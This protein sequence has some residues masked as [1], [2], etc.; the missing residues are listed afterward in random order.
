MNKEDLNLEVGTLRKAKQ[1]LQLQLVD[2]DNKISALH[3]KYVEEYPHSIKVGSKVRIK[4][5][6]KD[7][8]GA[9]N[10]E[11][12]I[13]F[14]G[15]NKYSKDYDYWYSRIYPDVN[16]VAKLLKVKKNGTPSERC[17]RLTGNI[18]EIEILEQ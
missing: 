1:E 5:S 12:I 13:A 2:I 16:V 17:E 14:I 3:R 15:E 8:R 10:E 18:V 4:S 11:E 7:Y 6:W 9:N